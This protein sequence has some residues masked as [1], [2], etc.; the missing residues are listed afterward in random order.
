MAL[1]G[2][3]QSFGALIIGTIMC[4]LNKSSRRFIM[5]KFITNLFGTKKAEPVAPYK[6][7]TPSFP[8]DT[9]PVV[10]ATK[11]VVNG[12]KAPTAKPKTA[13]ATGNTPAKKKVSSGANKKSQT[14][15]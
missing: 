5:L 4:E 11:P 8:V 1:Q 12:R 2:K 15:K 13:V 6:I 3:M 9:T 10:N 14:K 7:E